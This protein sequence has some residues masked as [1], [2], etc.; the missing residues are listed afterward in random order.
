MPLQPLTVETML[1]LGDC[2]YTRPFIKKLATKYNLIV[3]TPWPELYADLNVNFAMAKT[4][5]RT[6]YKNI[7]K[8]NIKW[9]IP[10]GKA[11]R[12]SYNSGELDKMSMFASL[13]KSCGVDPDLL[14]LPEFEN[15]FESNNI[16]LK[17]IELSITESNKP[18]C[19]VRPATIR[20]EWPA[21]S[22][23]PLPEYIAKAVDKIK[24]KYTVIS[25]ADLLV[26]HE[27]ALSPLPYADYKF[28]KGE[29]TTK[30]LL[31][32][33]QKADLVIGGVGFILPA[34]IA[35]KTNI[36]CILGGNGGYNSPEKI[37][38]QAMDLS[39]VQFIKPDALCMC[40]DKAHNCNKTISDFDKQLEQCLENIK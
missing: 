8:Q 30:Q 32:L 26:G 23:N 24:D 10:Q 17:L 36:I 28:H 20:T 18:I 9:C 6:Q 31:G 29:L 35:A 22:R 27:S 33:I 39:K 34:C 2:I 11:I 4:N 5:L 25:I 13:K 15:V 12:I 16:E 1:G 37:T 7:L 14:D 40:K 3:K 19:I 21:V 38:D